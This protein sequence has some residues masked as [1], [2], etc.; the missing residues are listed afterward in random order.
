MK[1][2]AI[3]LMVSADVKKKLKVKADELGL[4]LTSF[5]E[6]IA[7]EEIIFLDRNVKKVA[8]LFKIS[9]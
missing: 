1:N 6:K 4:T 5:F 2:S 8:E 9:M 7:L 3:N